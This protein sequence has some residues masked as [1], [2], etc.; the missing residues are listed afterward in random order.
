VQG[1]CKGSGGDASTPNAVGA[2][3]IPLGPHAS[4]D[5]RT[6]CCTR[7]RAARRAWYRLAS[8]SAASCHVMRVRTVARACSRAQIVE[9]ELL[10]ESQARE[11]R[12]ASGWHRSVHGDRDICCPCVLAHPRRQASCSARASGGAGYT[13]AHMWLPSGELVALRV[14]AYGVRVVVNRSP[15]ASSAGPRPIP[16]HPRASTP[17]SIDSQH[18]H[19]RA[20]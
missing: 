17:R 16:D 14:R 20:S 19:S 7:S 13:L 15:S 8:V 9:R 4:Q 11:Q 10:L 2:R 5:S 18:L 6:M 1:A 12:R 3:G